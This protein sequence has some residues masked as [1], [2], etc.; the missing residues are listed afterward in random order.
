VIRSLDSDQ[1]LRRTFELIATTRGGPGGLRRAVRASREGR[2]AVDGVHDVANMPLDEE[3]QQIRDDL[4]ALVA[5]RASATTDATA[6]S[7]SR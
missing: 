7:N 4:D 3:P 6:S 2:G 5:R 1:A